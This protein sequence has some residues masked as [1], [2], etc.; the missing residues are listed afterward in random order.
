[1]IAA[2][3]IRVKL[4]VGPRLSFQAYAG[5]E[6]HD[7]LVAALGK[8]RWMRE[9]YFKPDLNFLT[10]AGRGRIH[11]WLVLV[12]LL[13]NYPEQGVMLP[14]IGLRSLF[15]RTREQ[16]KVFNGISDP[17][18]REPAKLIAG[19]ESAS[20]G[21]PVLATYASPSR[22]AIILYPVVTNDHPE[23]VGSS[24]DPHEVNLCFELWAPVSSSPRNE[25]LVQF[26][27]KNHAA[28]HEAIVPRA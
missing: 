25:P 23:A 3:D 17:L 16:G 14:K 20:A 21:D 8:L 18:H 24:I 7:T 15:M 27:T 19:V 1:L 10:E 28:E 4:T 9:G 26:R 13:R 5:F 12:P 11:D 2:A 6:S 22:G